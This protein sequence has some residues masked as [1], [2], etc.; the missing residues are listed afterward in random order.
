MEGDLA[1]SAIVSYAMGYV[2]AHHNEDIRDILVDK[3]CTWIARHWDA[4]DCWQQEN[5]TASCQYHNKHP[6]V[7]RLISWMKQ[8]SKNPTGNEA[9]PKPNAE[10]KLCR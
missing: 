9:T 5:I 1:T 6:D 4:F 7:A 10:R 8:H 2:V 3:V